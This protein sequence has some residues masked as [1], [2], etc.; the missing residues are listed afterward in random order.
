MSVPRVRARYLATGILVGL[1]APVGALSLRYGAVLAGH[2]PP[3]LA[4]F[5]R[6]E[7]SGNPLYYLYLTF[8][9]LTVCLLAAWLVGTRTDR[10]AILTR[11]LEGLAM[12]DPVTGLFNRRYME[13]RLATEISRAERTRRPLSCLVVRIAEFDRLQS[14]A[15]EPELEPVLCDMAFLLRSTCRDLDVVGRHEPDAFLLVLPETDLYNAWIVSTRVV[16][17]VIAGRFTLRGAPL[18]VSVNIG[19]AEVDREVRW[20]DQLLAVSE[21]ALGRAVAAGVN[22]VML[23]DPASRRPQDTPHAG[24]SA[25]APA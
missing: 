18:P 5:V 23:H 9:A 3:G 21:A 25:P 22:R 2:A 10:V 17:A 13:H 15:S 20:S 24:P 11:R 12:R 14:A 8:G 7:L 6:E 4:V 19:G 1:A 16:E